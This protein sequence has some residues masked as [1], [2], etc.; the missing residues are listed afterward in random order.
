MARVLGS[1][2]LPRVT[3]LKV[4]LTLPK[5]CLAKSLSRDRCHSVSLTPPGNGR[6][7]VCSP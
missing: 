5:V 4:K 3:G 1:R 6:G 2:E 7:T